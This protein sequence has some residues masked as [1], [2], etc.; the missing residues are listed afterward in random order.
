MT[1]QEV[2]G[3]LEDA[4][5]SLEKRVAGLELMVMHLVDFNNHMS[6]FNKAFLEILNK[7][8]D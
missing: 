3:P 7:K 2:E 8:D 5:I 6:K 4:L 1:E